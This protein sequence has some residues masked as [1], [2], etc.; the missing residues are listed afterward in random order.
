[1]GFKRP[2]IAMP[3]I[4]SID[5]PFDVMVGVD[6]RLKGLRLLWH[7][8]W[9]RAACAVVAGQGVAIERLQRVVLREPE[10]GERAVAFQEAQHRRGLD[11]MHLAITDGLDESTEPDRF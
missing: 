10:G 1:M 11:E 2:A 4:C 5:Q 3:R 9:Q 6:I 8:E 7:A